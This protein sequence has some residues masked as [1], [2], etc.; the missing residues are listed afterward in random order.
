[1]YKLYASLSTPQCGKFTQLKR[2]NSV[3]FSLKFLKLIR[4]AAMHNNDAEI[5]KIRRTR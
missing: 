1:M 4:S 5:W 2:I 3:I